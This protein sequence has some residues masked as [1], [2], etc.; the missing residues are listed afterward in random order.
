MRELGIHPVTAQVLVGRG[1]LTP[2]AARA[3]LYASPSGL[4]DPALLTDMVRAAERVELALSRGERIAVYGDYD[5]D[6]VCS[7]A[8][9]TRILQAL[10]GNVRPYI[11]HR[12]T[13]GY[14]LNGEALQRLRAEG[15]GLVVTVDNGIT[16]AAA[17]AE[18]IAAGL[19]VDRK[20]VV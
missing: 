10:G 17:V 14:G 13:D 16:R 8:V 18:A 4:H 1:L 6:G 2:D 7:T 15:C 11:P 19:D 5:V 9:M 20:S 3:F 12:V